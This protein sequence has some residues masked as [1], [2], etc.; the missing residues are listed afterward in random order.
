MKEAVQPT[1][2][3]GNIVNR[4]RLVYSYLIN[5]GRLV[6]NFFSLPS[7]LFSSDLYN[8]LLKRSRVWEELSSKGQS[9]T[10]SHLLLVSQFAKVVDIS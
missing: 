9:P 4:G 1:F 2:L 5:E 6:N 3:L 7:S 8:S 10:D